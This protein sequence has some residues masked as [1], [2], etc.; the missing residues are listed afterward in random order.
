M[1]HFNPDNTVCHALSTAFDVVWV[2]FLWLLCCVPVVTIGASTA[3]MFAA[4][5]PV[6]SRSDTG[7][8][9]V[10]FS[11][12]YEN[13][14]C[15]TLCWL[16]ICLL[17]GILILDFAACGSGALGGATESL[18][19]ITAFLALLVA[20]VV[21]YLFGGIAK[22]R[23]T[24]AQALKNAVLFAMRF[25][26]HTLALLALE[27]LLFAMAAFLLWYALLPSGILL[28]LQAKILNHAFNCYLAA[29]RARPEE[30]YA[31]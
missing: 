26:L 25:P 17:G 21:P 9:K 22:F 3:A 2:S 29:G 12:F 11:R 31:E 6:C 8:T 28:W 20:A 14:R 13:F 18:C 24:A 16:L 15:A 7:V 23:V 1:F 4:Y 5:L 10:F 27:A 30:E 19:G